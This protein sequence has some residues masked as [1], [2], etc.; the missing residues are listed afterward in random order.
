M[1]LCSQLVNRS[2]VVPR[3]GTWVEISTGT[4]L[5]GVPSVVP[6]MGTWV[7]IP[8]R[9]LQAAGGAVVPRMGTWVEMER[10]EDYL[11]NVKRRP[12]HGDVG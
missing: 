12:P 3:M 5:L 9:G 6:R 8:P 7:E 10:M 11:R 4:L 1:E 2:R